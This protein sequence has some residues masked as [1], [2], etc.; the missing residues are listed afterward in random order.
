[1][2]DRENNHAGKPDARHRRTAF[3]LLLVA[4]GMV[5]MSFAAVPLYQIFCQVTG[6]GGTIQRADQ[7]ADHVLDRKIT[8]RFDTTV[9]PKLKWKFAPV[10][11]TMTVKIGENRLA[12]FKAVNVSDHTI[13]GTASFNVTPEAAGSY[14][15]KIQCFCFTEQRL[16]AG[17][18][19]DMP[20]SFFVDPAIVDDPDARDIQEITL[21]YTFFKTK[22]EG[23]TP[24][25]SSAKSSHAKGDHEGA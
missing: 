3:V 6:Y 5:G 17:Q 23:K 25:R 12:F 8:I 21:S 20:V 24:E 16:A 1:M 19:A 9:S 14:F 10:Q 11:R 13:V 4:A 22:D 7:G 2:T 15:N 18:S